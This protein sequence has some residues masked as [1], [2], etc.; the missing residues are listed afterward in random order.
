MVN[1]FNNLYKNAMEMCSEHPKL[2]PN[3]L[4][5]KNEN[6]PILY[7][8]NVM[9]TKDEKYVCNELIIISKELDCYDVTQLIPIPSFEVDRNP[10]HLI[11]PYKNDFI[12][13]I[14]DTYEN[15]IIYKI[16]FESMKC[17]NIINTNPV[18]VN[19]LNKSFKHWIKNTV[20]F[21]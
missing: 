16:Y 17:M 2:L 6:V 14:N 4:V 9:L 13:K 12:V 15:S 11:L 7:D 5:I 3:W 10:G 20:C 18:K 8:M 1:K 19:I 21:C